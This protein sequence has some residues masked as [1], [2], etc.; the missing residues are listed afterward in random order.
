M[1]KKVYHGALNLDEV[2]QALASFFNRGPLSAHLSRNGD[3]AFLQ[4]ATRRGNHSGGQTSLSVA[5]RQVTDRLEVE[6]GKQNMLGIAGSLGASAVLALLH[7]LNLLGR[8][9]D[10][11]QDFENLELD[12]QV[13]KV[14][15]GLAANAGASHELSERL[16]RLT[17]NY[18]Q[19]ANPVGESRCLA[20]GA[21][22]GDAQP[23]ACP[24]C[25]YILLAGE[26]ECP[27]CGQ[28]IL[29]EAPQRS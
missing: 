6:I 15:E 19:V 20:C 13:W 2:A 25:G 12:E 4:I 22:L 27:N 18:C 10:I 14:L 29:Y 17:C 16:K 7:P 8:L 23:I 21:P 28:Q 3:Q 1:Q 26:A 11:A 5:L 9:D 24:N